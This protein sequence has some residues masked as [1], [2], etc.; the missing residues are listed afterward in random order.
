[1]IH[2]APY[3]NT[4]EAPVFHNTKPFKRLLRNASD[5]TINRMN[6]LINI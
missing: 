1:M 3:E 4:G 6:N 5:G 2:L